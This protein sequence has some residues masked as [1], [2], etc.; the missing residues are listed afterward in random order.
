MAYYRGKKPENTFS[1]RNVW[2]ETLVKLAFKSAFM[3]QLA[4]LLSLHAI[5]YI[6]CEETISWNTVRIHKWRAHDIFREGILATHTHFLAG[7]SVAPRLP[8]SLPKADLSKAAEI[9]P[10]PC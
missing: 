2:L 3:V 1:M 9:S 6:F 10:R 5:L 7:L 4:K 8:C